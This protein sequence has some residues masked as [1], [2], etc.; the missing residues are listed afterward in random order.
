MSGEKIKIDKLKAGNFDLEDILVNIGKVEVDDWD[1]PMGPTPKPGIKDLRDW[2]FRLLKR[3]PPFYSPTCDMCCFCTYGKCDLSGDKRGACGIDLKTQSGRRVSLECSIGS[4]CHAGHSRHLLHW[5]IEKVGGDFPIDLGPDVEIEAPIYRVVVGSRPKT[6]ADLREGM[7]YCEEEITHVLST[8]HVGQEGSYLDRESKALHV[9]M[10]D[11]LGKEI[12]DIAQIVALN[13]HKG[14]G[15]EPLVEHGFASFDRSKPIIT[16]IGHNVAAASEALEYMHEHGLDGQVELGGICCTAIDMTRISSSPKIVASLAQQGKFT[17]SGIADVIVVDEQ[18]IRADVLEESQKVKTPVIA[19]NDKMMLGLDDRTG[20]DNNA[21]IEDLTSG[22]IP[23]VAVLDPTQAGELMV[24]LAVK[25][26]PL[27]ANVRALP[28][29]KEVIELAKKCTECEACVRICPLGIHISDLMKSAAKG[30]LEPLSKARMLCISCMRCNSACEQ[31]LPITSMMERA[32]EEI[33]AKEKVKVRAGRGPVTDVEIRKVGGPIVFGEI[34]GIIAI[35]GC[36][37]YPGSYLEL[38]KVADE[39]LSRNYIVATTGCSAIDL[40]KYEDKDG[41]NLYEKYPG[42]FDGGCLSNLGSCLSNAHAIG[43]AIKVAHIFA[44]RDL[45]GNFEEIADYIYNRVGAVALVWGTMSSK[46]VSIC[47]GITRWGIPVIYGPQGMKYRR[48]M[49]GRKDKP[50]FWE[51]YNTRT[52][53]KHIADPAPEHLIYTPENIDECIVYTA[54]LCIRAGDNNKGRMIKLSHYIDLH[55]KYFGTMPDDLHR[56]IR[57]EQD[58][59]FNL[60]DEIMK[61]LKKK[62]WKPREMIDPTIVPRL[63]KGGK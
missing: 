52:G 7:D 51:T 56:Y 45:R 6:L 43:A 38:G 37:N 2:D 42:D 13:M 21:I 23:G 63:V 32:A 49:L 58:I 28:N 48:L 61:D 11:N 19:T 35:A 40:G 60:K 33:I 53:K 29:R 5:L 55:K 3:Y 39:F 34:P 41:M 47:T 54:K 4:A 1:E 20:D 46:A 26:K 24:K 18:C 9:S 44:K 57:V 62:K 59:P 16:C 12:G 25:M 10:V 14:K 50:E 36:A 27:R 15:D 31:G 17:K 30:D 22:K 8:I